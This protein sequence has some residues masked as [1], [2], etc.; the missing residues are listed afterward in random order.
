MDEDMYYD[1]AIALLSNHMREVGLTYLKIYMKSA[2]LGQEKPQ[3]VETGVGMAA[4]DSA[5]M[6]KGNKRPF[7]SV[8]GKET[9][10]QKTKEPKAKGRKQPIVAL[11][12]MQCPRMW[13][14]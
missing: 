10:D 7:E 6:W 9:A 14:T 11:S 5:G 4:K 3:A 13:I 12:I 2:A 1:M 8:D